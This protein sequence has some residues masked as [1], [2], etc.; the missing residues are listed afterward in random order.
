ML[1]SI[2]FIMVDNYFEMFTVHLYNCKYI[3]PEIKYVKKKLKK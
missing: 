1:T 3:N 2:I